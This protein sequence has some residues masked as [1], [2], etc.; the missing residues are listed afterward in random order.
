MPDM[1]EKFTERARKVLTLAQEEAHRF[2]HS[3]LG[4]EHLLL[5]LVREGD[6]VAARVLG[7]KGVQLPKVRSAVEF[8]VGRGDSMIVG[9]IGLTPRAQNVIKLAVDEARRLNHH[10][11]GTEHLLLGLLREGEGIACG[12]LESL[13]VN[14]EAVR[15]DVLQV[16]SHNSGD[17]PADSI[18][19]AA[20]A[21]SDLPPQLRRGASLISRVK[22]GDEIAFTTLFRRY[23][24]EVRER[25]ISVV[26]DRNDA[27]TLMSECVERTRQ[28]FL[29]TPEDL[30]VSSWLHRIITNACDDVLR[31]RQLGEVRLAEPLGQIP[32]DEAW[33]VRQ[34]MNPRLRA[35]LVLH[36]LEGMS[37]DE[38]AQALRISP[39]A[40]ESAI[41]YAR[42]YFRRLDREMHAPMPE[43]DSA[44]A[45]I[46]RII[47]ELFPGRFAVLLASDQEVIVRHRFPNEAGADQE[48]RAIRDALAP[49]A[50]P[51]EDAGE[52][53]PEQESVT[54][55]EDP[56]TDAK[57]VAVDLARWTG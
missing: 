28:A 35:V 40:A 43:S 7:S 20:P 16:V 46:E 33:Q 49:T 1:F 23:E 32:P 31:R 36:E 15:G 11:I 41:L 37:D 5:G 27:E 9:E 13:G 54:I 39:S 6:G 4:T 30:I 51:D 12:V 38:I 48:L 53:L 19:G 55:H 25:L 57:W 47:E 52:S 44:L 17:Q 14:L 56:T 2:N 26:G 18:S 42:E 34:R 50:K 10:Y 8:I 24:P 29:H 3:Y 45:Q 21:R 22:A